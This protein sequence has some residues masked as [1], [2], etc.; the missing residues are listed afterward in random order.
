MRQGEP[1]QLASGPQGVRKADR[2]AAGVRRI[3][4][5]PEVAPEV[6]ESA[7]SARVE[8]GIGDEI[9]GEAL[10]DAAGVEAHPGRQRHGAALWVELDPYQAGGGPGSRVVGEGKGVRVISVKSRS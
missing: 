2:P 4:G 10:A 5:G 8:E 9:G 7:E 6:D 1:G 3:A